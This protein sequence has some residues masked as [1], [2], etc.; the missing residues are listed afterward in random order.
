MG[1]QPTEDIVICGGVYCAVRTKHLLK[2]LTVIN[3]ENGTE[4]TNC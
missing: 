1:Q 4:P 2:D 3:Q